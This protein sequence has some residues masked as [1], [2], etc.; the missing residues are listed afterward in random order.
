MNS[1]DELR[2]KFVDQTVPQAEY[3]GLTVPDPDLR[4]NGE[5]GHYDFSEPDWGE[6]MDVIAGNGPCSADRLEAKNAAWAEGAWV[7]EGLLAH[8]EKR[9]ASKVAAE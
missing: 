9:R 7:R 4:W 1:N 6:F 8:G 3:L 5:T 2:Q